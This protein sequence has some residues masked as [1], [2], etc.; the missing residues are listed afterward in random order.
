MKDRVYSD[1]QLELLHLWQDNKLNRINLL[2]GSVRSGKTWISLVL[3]AFWVATMPQD[4]S[5]LMA[6]KTITSL[7][8]NCLDLLQALVGEK[9]FTYSIPRKEARLFGRLVYLEGVNDARA[10]NKIRGMTLQGAYCDELTLFTEDFFAMLLSRL[11][12]S[13][14]KLIATTNPDTP[15]HWLMEKYIK[16]KDELDMLTMKFLLEDNFTLD[17]GYVE[18]L[19]KEYTGVFYDRFVL[20]NWVRAEGAI[21]KE[22]SENEQEF[23]ID[24]EKIPA[25]EYV[26]VG[27]DFGGNKSNHAFVACGIAKGF[28]ALYV[29]KAATYTATGTSPEDLYNIF[30]AF[31]AEIEKRHGNIDFIFADS[32][33]QV[34]ISGIRNNCGVNVRNSLKKEIIDRIRA[35][36]SLMKQ[37]R[38]KLVRGECDALAR[39]FREASYNEKCLED[40]RL[41]DGTSDIDSLDSFEYAWERYIN[42]FIRQ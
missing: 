33:E 39:A 31:R 42:H 24:Q 8:R 18:N 2:E 13:G 37:R 29:L 21:Y 41:D 14:A 3:W 19:K 6:A 36:T 15:S 38:L 32:A 35:T 4:A 11:S 20:G 17:V 30:N 23:Y 40:K 26:T 7:R 10:E 9:H 16:R 28:D 22:F 34:L 1:K 27:I 25:L 5:Y 12:V